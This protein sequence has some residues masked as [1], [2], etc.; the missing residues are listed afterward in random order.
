MSWHWWAVY[1]GNQG[2]SSS[3]LA[4]HFQV[5]PLSIPLKILSLFSCP[6][7]PFL[8]FLAQ[9]YTP[10]GRDKKLVCSC[11]FCPAVGLLLQILRMG[12]ELKPVLLFLVTPLK[13][14]LWHIRV[15]S[16]QSL[17]QSLLLNFTGL[18]VKSKFSN[19][20]F[21]KKAALQPDE[22]RWDSWVSKGDVCGSRKHWEINFNS[23][24]YFSLCGCLKTFD[25]IKGN[26]FI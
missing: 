16:H 21:Q 24:I 23:L 10:K 1:C 19:K 11:S 15:I 7:Q 8:L 2:V 17:E 4:L 25:P 20:F 12:W 5:H 26:F 6:R 14:I 22:P 3:F 13:I 9:L 18:S